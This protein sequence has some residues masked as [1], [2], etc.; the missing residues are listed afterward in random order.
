MAQPETLF[1]WSETARTEFDA[2]VDGS[3]ASDRFRLALAQTIA[4]GWGANRDKPVWAL[5]GTLALLGETG[6]GL[7]SALDFLWLPANTAFAHLGACRHP[8]VSANEGGSFHLKLPGGGL[9]L[10]RFRL[11]LLQKYLEFLISCDG[12]AHSGEVAG[13]LDA[14]LRG[15][16]SD[17]GAIDTAVKSIAKIL[18]RYRTEHFDD[19]HATS[20]F[21]ILRAYLAG[22]GDT[23]TDDTVFEFWSAETNSH[24]KTYQA[25]F[26]A[27]K[28]YV[29]ALAEA[30]S[31]AAM[32]RA[33]EIDA[34][35]IAAE[36]SVDFV[37]P[38]EFEDEDGAAIGDVADDAEQAAAAATGSGE[39]AA[40]AALKAVAD[41]EV[42][43]IK[44]REEM[45]AAPIVSAGRFG[46]SLPLATLRLLAFHP[47]QSAL[48]NSLRTGKAT[49]SLEERVTCVEA[50]RY[51]VLMG[52]I[53]DLE[54]AMTEW[55]KIAFAIRTEEA[56]GNARADAIRAEG[57]QLLKTRRS[58]S[59]ARPREELAD[60]FERVERALMALARSLADFRAAVRGRR[61]RSDDLDSG[62][63]ADRAKFAAQLTKL[64][65]T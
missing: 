21:S 37:D 41:S 43:L 39:E 31:R 16:L 33:G 9:L 51:G 40:S 18:Y 42:K 10:D 65:A 14:C 59:L 48:S 29:D 6:A 58:Q 25:S 56:T 50:R 1:T 2:L 60:A 30:R 52:E 7:K 15:G 64:Y 32:R 17:K 61:V 28:D 46:C 11:K 47:I 57:V 53:G 19:G 20:A 35:G 45:L 49:L 22:I 38:F 12:F 44:K 13:L 3:N 5:A 34:P 4:S 27:L 62:F 8:A 36:L 55:L 24:F 54:T 63:E 23:I 26:F